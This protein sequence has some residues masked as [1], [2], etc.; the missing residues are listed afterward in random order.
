MQNL[1]IK[2]IVILH[3]SIASYNKRDIC[4]L[5]IMRI[6]PSPACRGRLMRGHES[7]LASLPMK[8][9]DDISLEYYLRLKD[10][11][12]GERKML[13]LTAKDTIRP[14]VGDWYTGQSRHLFA[15]L[16]LTLHGVRSGMGW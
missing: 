7:V 13:G 8:Y 16:A 9:K 11:E 4:A 5:V 15:A 6:S 2:I 10:V 1:G 12:I 3:S 14:R